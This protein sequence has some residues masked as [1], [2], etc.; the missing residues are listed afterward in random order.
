MQ[1]MTVLQSL[2]TL[3]ICIISILFH[4]DGEQNSN[5]DPHI[6]WLSKASK[7]VDGPRLET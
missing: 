4:R 1:H 6:V 3:R 5:S 2:L 7:N